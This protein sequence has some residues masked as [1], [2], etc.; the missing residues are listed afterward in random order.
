MKLAVIGAGA[1]GL[2]AAHDFAR[3][4]HDVVV[5]E[6]DSQVGGLAA[7]FREPEWAWSV[8]RY[9]HH[10]FASDRAVLGLIDELGWRDRVLFPWPSTAVY[11]EGRFYKLDAPLS[12]AT[13]GWAWAD[14]LPGAGMLARGVHLLRFPPLGV[15]DKLR[16]GVAA[17]VLLAAPD[18][19]RF[20][21]TTAHAWLERWMGPRTYRLLWQPLLE[22]K[23]GPHYRDV[24]MAWFWARVKARTPRLGTFVGGFQAF[25]DSLA[26]EVRRSGGT[27]RLNVAV[28]KIEPEAAGGLT[29]TTRDG[30]ETFDRC[31]V[32]TSPELLARLAPSL[33][34]AYLQGLRSLKAMGAVVLIL[35]L[36]H[37][38]SE[39]GVY[40]H[41]LP[42]AAGFPFLALV[43]HTNFL[44]KEHF[45]GDHLVYLGDYL[46]P[47]HEYFSLTEGELLD[48]FLPSLNRV[49]PGFERTW[50]RKSWL[51]RT[52]Y[53]QPIPPLNHS[54]AIP[55]LQT[56]V[57]GLWFASMSQVYPWDRGTNFAVEVARRAA[58]EMLASR[59]PS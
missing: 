28:D 6:A 17:L 32:T 3:A 52:P 30:R 54:R 57:P 27:V 45:N 53:A 22:G 25:L 29:V 56:P 37:R 34:E 51:F 49:N 7:G 55:P 26:A 46:D 14:R 11:H 5:F 19:R 50:V 31:L 35:A 44:P 58:Q 48:R 33:P 4:G 8:E 9:Y 16:Y 21:R 12:E 1:G 24:N 13:P 39:Q 42:K 23:F 43:E 2:A 20:E 36:R 40:W 10:W 38:L 15:I 59:E 47:D 41:N 18:W